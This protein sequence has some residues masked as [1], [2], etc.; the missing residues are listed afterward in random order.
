MV[1][2]LRFGSGSTGQLPEYVIYTDECI[3]ALRASDINAVEV[4][5]GL[6]S[7]LWLIIRMNRRN[8]AACLVRVVDSSGHCSSRD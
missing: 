5:K 3:I 2:D 7:T 4:T 1:R 8:A 6:D